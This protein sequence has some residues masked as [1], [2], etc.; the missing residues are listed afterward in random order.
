MV[1]VLKTKTTSSQY[2]IRYSTRIFLS[3]CSIFLLFSCTVAL[4]QWRREVVYNREKLHTR[5]QLYNQFAY[6]FWV[7]QDKNFNALYQLPHQL[8]EPQLRVTFINREGIV[9]FDNTISKDSLHTNHATR[10]EIVG[11][12]SATNSFHIR[13]SES[14]QREFFYSACYIDSLYVR[15]SLPYSIE[16]KESLKADSGFIYFIILV[17]ILM[18]AVLLSISRQ[19]GKSI[20]QLRDFA[21]SAENN[22]I[23]TDLIFPDDELGETSR[24][25]THIYTQLQQAREEESKMRRQLTQNIAHELKTPVSSIQGFMETIHNNPDLPADKVRLFLDRCY[26]Q[27]IRLTALINDIS[28]LNKI[29]ERSVDPAVEVVNIYQMVSEIEMDLSLEVIK[30][31]AHIQ[32]LLD[33]RVLVDG[34][35]SLIYSIFRNLFDNALHYAGQ[36]IEICIDCEDIG[37]H[38]RFY[39]SDNGIGVAPAHLAHLF[40]RFYRVDKGRS[41]KQGGTGLGLAIVKNAVLYHRGSIEVQNKPSG[42]LLFI[43][44]LRKIF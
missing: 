44:T 20:S 34:N 4:F 14:L 3:I 43:F 26:A 41:R 25:I 18:L 11:S 21:F 10:P 28:L 31:E 32:N 13:F 8:R 12:Q 27:T 33:K 39:F 22:I 16:V 6:K 9:L 35:Y 19:I 24:H 37:D 5:L 30:R 38:Y 29:D 40:D 15:S 36:N 17:F 23:S 7:D 42:G 1:T 2:K